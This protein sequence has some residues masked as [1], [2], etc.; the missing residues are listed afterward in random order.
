MRFADGWP[1]WWGGSMTEDT[2]GWLEDVDGERAMAW[3]R[4]R[5]AEAEEEL[6][7]DPRFEPIRAGIQEALEADD[8]IPLVTV[9]GGHL[10][11]FWTDAGHERGLWRRTGWDSYLDGEGETEWEV[12]LDLD[13]LSS[14]EGEQWVWHGARILRPDH[15]RALVALSRGGSDA[16]VTREFDLTTRTFVPDGFVREEAKGSLSWVDRDTVYASTDVGP[17]SMS[18]SGYPL[19]VRRWTRGTPLSEAPEVFA[20]GPDDMVVGAEHDPTPGF[21]RELVACAHG[22]Y[23]EHRYLLSPDG[24]PELLDLPES[25][26]LDLHRQWLT[27]ELRHDWTVTQDGA[28][29]THAAGSLLVIELDRFRAG[30]RDF[31]TVFAP[32]EHSA[33]TDWF[34]TRSTLVLTVLRDVRHEVL[35]STPS[36]TGD[37]PTTSTL[38]TGASD[39]ATL[40][41][42]AVDADESDDLWLITTS[43]LSP[44]R[45]SLVRMGVGPAAADV[46]P[47]RAAPERFDAAGLELSQHWATSAD[48]TRVPYFQVAPRDLALDGTAPTVLHGYGGFEQA[49]TPAYDPIVGGA[50]LSRGGVYV[51]AGIRGGGEFGPRWHQAALRSERHRAYEDFVAVARDLV[52]RR[53]TSVP[54]LGCSGRSNGGLLVGNML[55]GFPDDFGA[56][57][58]QVPLL[59]MVRFSRLLAG[60]SWMAEY[61]NPD[62][63]EDRE[64]LLTFS[65]YHRVDGGRTY[66]PTYLATS[67]RDDRVHPGHA[68][69]MAELLR[70]LGQDVTYWE[71]TE[72]G[73][74]GASTPAQWSVWHALP[75]TFLHRRLA[76][77]DPGSQS[78][79]GMSRT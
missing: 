70:G 33:L 20:G 62:V 30:E 51:V 73:H 39:L 37:A 24:H 77:G 2:L 69:K 11:N 15:D 43:W 16:D 18:S 19:T 3:V 64:S 36:A 63:P 58:C 27:V 29:T 17:G 74:G 21:E 66:P 38:E 59:D 14:A 40:T 10:Y 44:M 46:Q 75:W 67:T 76:T 42:S 1:P 35:V 71:N 52:A 4:D 55:T 54:H 9:V 25:S 49:L 53:V 78:S 22:F 79:T 32:D 57:V 13:R 56:V 23:S 48:G 12:L 8:R 65:P 45:L 72:G 61:G 7:A 28:E 41:V 60:A 47:V 34:W 6:R 68:R 5:S 50:W 26:R 31:R